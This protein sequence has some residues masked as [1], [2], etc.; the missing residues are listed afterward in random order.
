M[1][2]GK[3]EVTLLRLLDRGEPA[4]HGAS[5]V[6]KSLFDLNLVH[7]LACG[8]VQLT[9]TG[10]RAL[11]QAQCIEALAQAQAGSGPVIDHGVE[12]W[13]VSSGFLRADDQAITRR[14]QLWL[15]SLEPDQAA[16]TSADDRGAAPGRVAAG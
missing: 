9:K 11:F 2:L 15:A 1:K 16:A 6:P 13:L 12:R 10:E 3:E 8:T 7:R 4:P 5:S 14:G